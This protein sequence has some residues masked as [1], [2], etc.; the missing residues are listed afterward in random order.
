MKNRKKAA[1]K[2]RKPPAF[3][4]RPISLKTKNLPRRSRK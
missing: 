1:P 3:R 4:F 2:M